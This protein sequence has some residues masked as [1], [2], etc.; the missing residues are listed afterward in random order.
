MNAH[1]AATQETRL[2]AL[3]ATQRAAFL[4][5]GPPSLAQR[6]ADLK[7]L[8][9]ALLARRD[10][11]AQA[12]D[13]D[14]GHRSRYE[15]A[16]LDLV[17][18]VHGINYLRR[19]LKTWMRPQRR[20]IALHFQPGRARVVRQPLGVVGIVSPWNY[21]VSLA[22]MPLATAIAA[23][24]RAM[25][26]P[27]E[28]TPATNALLTALLREVF[29][30]EQ[31]AIV[32]GDADV[33]AAFVALPFDHLIFTGS[34]QVGR[35]VMR[36]A[37]ENLVPVTLELGGKSPVIIAPGFSLSQAAKSIAFGKLVN[38][39]QTCIAPDYALVPENEVGSFA[40]AYAEAVT[41]LYP[42]GASD[43]AYASI[44][45][46]GHYARLVGLVDDA[47][48]KGARIIE[49]GGAPNAARARTI[50]P[51]LVLNPTPEMAIM[52]N[53]IFGPVLPVVPYRE[54]DDAI[55][56]VNGRPRPLALYLFG[57]R[58]EVRAQILERTTSG[59]VTIND[60]LLHYAVEDLPF[61]GV[62]ESGI[63]AY[64]GEEGFKALS[65]AKGVFQQARW[66]FSGLLRSPFGR[67]TDLILAYLLR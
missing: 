12:V 54:T 49:I 53:E 47:R 35:A 21:P 44:I 17:P 50:A 52:Q 13:A 45:N 38:A 11:F 33:G 37:S 40:A 18:L 39:G 65:H 28:F 56:Y 19:N 61:G 66:N 60:T 62:G 34:T 26:K 58:R 46:A 41:K 9:T 32:T 57:R 59:N 29:P 20:R 15:T 8:K 4:R 24:N 22:L 14:F 3:L 43:A 63:G 23:G 64:H 36:A 42:D 10:A 2:T 5:D 30:E 27:S 31:A 67:I 6:R 48:Q 7:N 51:T 25:V 16:V 55:A 1:A